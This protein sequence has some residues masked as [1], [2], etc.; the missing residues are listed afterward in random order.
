MC[1]PQLLLGYPFS[2]ISLWFRQ[3]L[4]KLGLKIATTSLEPDTVVNILP[5]LAP[6]IQSMGN[7]NTDGISA[8]PTRILVFS[9]VPNTSVTP[10]QTN[11]P[12][13]IPTS[14]PGGFF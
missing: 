8:H 13:F 1:F 3:P 10:S 6:L 2:V 11:H 5:L 4:S 12:G 7:P 14:F 9:W